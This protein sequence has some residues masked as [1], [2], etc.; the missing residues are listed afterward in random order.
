MEF[1]DPRHI[2]NLL[3]EMKRKLSKQKNLNYVSI[4]AIHKNTQVYPYMNF[5]RFVYRNL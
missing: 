5:S 4:H 2:R 3:N 1:I